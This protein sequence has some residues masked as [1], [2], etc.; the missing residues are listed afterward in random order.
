MR[1]PEHQWPGSNP[2][3]RAQGS[4]PQSGLNQCL[5]PSS[6]VEG[7]LQGKEKTGD[8]IILHLSFYYFYL[9]ALMQQQTTVSP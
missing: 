1:K 3:R 8:P 5:Q 6:W 2:Y 4:R 9:I 7:L